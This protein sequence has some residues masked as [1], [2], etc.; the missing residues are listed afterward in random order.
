M[1]VHASKNCKPSRDLP[2]PPKWNEYIPKKIDT[3]KVYACIGETPP[4]G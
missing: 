1:A 2:D 4:W 3:Q